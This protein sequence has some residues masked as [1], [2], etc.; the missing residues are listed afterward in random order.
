MKLI[1]SLLGYSFI[2]VLLFRPQVLEV[3]VNLGLRRAILI[4]LFVSGFTLGKDLASK[5]HF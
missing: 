1:D 5:V 2:V 4:H 3:E